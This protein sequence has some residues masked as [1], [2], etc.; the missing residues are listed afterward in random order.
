MNP[1]PMKP[2]RTMAR[3]EVRCPRCRVSF[4]IGTRTCLHCG[5]R[6]RSEELVPSAAVP[7][8]SPTEQAEEELEAGRS[9]MR[10]ITGL[11][12]VALALAGSLYRACAG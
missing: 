8:V 3:Y 10:L 2:A 6:I 12:W 5:S 1:R 4:P 7:A 11:V 9:P